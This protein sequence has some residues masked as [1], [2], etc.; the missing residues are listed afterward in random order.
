MELIR[1]I[2]G[3]ARARVLAPP[4]F[5]VAYVAAVSCFGAVGFVAAMANTDW[6]APVNRAALWPMA[7]LGVAAFV[8]EVKPLVMSRAFGPAETTS[9]SAPFIL[10]LV[11]VGGVGFAVLTQV[12]A[13]LADDILR[14][15]EFKKSA[16]NAAQYTLS[17]LAARFVF[18]M[19]AGVPFFGGPVSVNLSLLGPLLAGGI[20][21]VSVN[22]LLVAIVVAIAM[23]QPLRHTLRADVG[24]YAAT[25][26]VLLCIGGVAANVAES[27]VAFLALLCAPAIAV[28]M[29]TDAAIRHDYQTSHDSLTGVGNRDLAFSQLNSAFVAARGDSTNG[30]G[31]VL[32]DLDHFKDVNDTLGHPVGDELLRQV[33]KRLVAALGDNPLVNRL[34]GDEF[35]VVVHGG[36][37]EST[38]LARDLLA[39][40]E[41]PMRVGEVELLVRASAGVAVAPEHGTD[42]TTLM[43]NADI[44]M[45]RAKLERDGTSTY[46]PEFDVNTLERLQL[47]ADLRAAIGTAQLHV[48]YQ[49]QVDL[50]S[51]RTVGVEALI[52]WHDPIRGLVPPDSFIP[53]AENSGLIVELTFYVLD[54]ALGTLAE[55]RA[56]GYD[57]H[58]A[59]NLSAR[60]LSDLALPGQVAE[61]LNRHS[62]PPGAL[63]LEVTETGILS[64]PARVDTVISALRTLGVAIA[65]DDYGTGHAS[66]S[67]LK[68]LEVDELKV[69]KSFVSNMGRDTHDFIIVRSTIALARDLGLRV[70][71]E[72]IEDE[73]TALALRDLGCHIGQGY[74]LGRP[75]TADQIL[76]RLRDEQQRATP[77]H[78]GSR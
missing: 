47:L 17:V 77:S 48:A 35:A 8:G 30:P 14:H 71:A 6:A 65:V 27:G 15:R 37:A 54:T 31:L 19:L 61:A 43:K 73:E 22:W 58:M 4:S 68:Q 3:G 69:D 55:W 49:P 25:Q 75:A 7:F 41:A 26:V 63:V 18:S 51:M 53:L 72:G 9:T 32:L 64:V 11:S 59:V 13:S 38:A 40:L 67:Y 29:A 66:L 23:S 70:V 12:V 2:D 78:A 20:A 5:L 74:H 1:P 42:V 10:A 45:Y 36:L 33:A 52:R 56:A 24:F 57:L 28:Y 76:L 60:H 16:F 44:A 62:I 34:G 46:S 21:M 39:S 50:I